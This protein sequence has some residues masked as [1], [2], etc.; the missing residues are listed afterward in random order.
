MV[1]WIK[2]TKVTT[3][4]DNLF[5][6]RLLRSEIGLG[7]KNM[8]AAAINLLFGILAVAVGREI[9]LGPKAVLAN[10]VFHPLEPSR[11][12]RVVIRKI[13]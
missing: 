13:K 7:V 9:A 11:I 4:F 5:K 1:F 3:R 10:N 2:V 8:V 12:L 6:Q